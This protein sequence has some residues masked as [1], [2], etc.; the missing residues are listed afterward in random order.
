MDLVSQEKDDM[1]ISVLASGSSGNVTYIETPKRKILVDA[2]LSGKKIANLMTSIGRNIADVDSLLVT[3]EHTDHCKGVGVL[4]R[5]YNLDV[6]A[7]K[8]TWDAM[9]N[10][11][12]NIPGEQKHLFGMG[13]TKSFVDLD[14]ES[15]GVSHDAAEPQFYQ[16]HHNGHSF[17]ILTDTGYVSER[18][19][20]VIKNADGYL[21]ECNHD[22]EMLRMGA[23]PWSLKQ[24][25]LSDRGHLSNDDGAS[26][27]IDVLGNR[28]KQIYL[29]HLSKDN[30][31]KELAHLTVETAMKQQDLGVNEDFG[32][33]DTDP[34]KATKLVEI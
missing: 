27:L 7:N 13:E 15:F 16:F 32:I 34:E 8:G 26:A 29:G 10:K 23:Y 21:I 4:A 3:H 12:G 24:R 6:Y 22:T 25:I 14:V 18:T 31:V 20:G 11:I 1:K 9:S 30:N 19:E 2:G 5:K 33:Y 28:T 17:V